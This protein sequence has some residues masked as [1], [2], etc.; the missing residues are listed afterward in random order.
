[1]LSRVTFG[2]AGVLLLGLTVLRAVECWSTDS[3]LEHVAGVWVAQA[4][5]LTRG[6]FYRAPYGS[7]GYGGTR[8]FPLFFS[9]HGA[10]I[11]VFGDWRST[12]YALSAISVVLLL[13]AVYYLSRRIG[14]G[15][16]LAVAACLA[17]LA[18]TSVQEALLTIRE[19]AMAA[20]LNMWGVAICAG[21]YLGQRRVHYAAALFTLAFA[22]KETTVFGAAAMF[23][24]LLLNER[25]RSAL[26]LLAFTAGGYVLV[27]AGIY[28]G[29]G[30]RAFEVFRLTAAPG[31]TLRSILFSPSSVVDAMNGYPGETILLALGTATLLGTG[32]RNMRRIPTLLFL[33]TLVVTVFIFS[34]DGIAGNHLIDLQIASAALVVDWALQAGAPDFAIGASA[35]ACLIVW[36]G[37]MPNYGFTDTVPVRAQLKDVINVIGRTDQTIL[38]ENPLVP[39]IAGQQPY[40]TDPFNFRVMVE[41]RPSLGEP[42]WQML[43]ERR[44]AAVVLMHDP[45]SDDFRDFYA[46][47]SLGQAFMERLQQDY[48]L[49]GTPGRQYLYLPRAS[50]SK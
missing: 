39:I 32:A 15:T 4:I 25:R 16:W 1:V 50:A 30:G 9:L 18:G 48:E 29:S 8:Y 41:K 14:A 28:L 5:D 40:L 43:H 42:M 47:T 13:V 17:A 21:E 46:R 23:L 31:I 38:S 6:V 49:A 44:F 2:V 20:M 37:L 35:A 45:N 36:L 19:D 26:C 34:S 7:F 27:M 12:G 10:A 11:R 33:C 22:V 3:H 24:Y